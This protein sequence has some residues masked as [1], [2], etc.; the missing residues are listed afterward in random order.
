MTLWR[1]GH[2]L[3]LCS[4]DVHKLHLGSALGRAPDASLGSALI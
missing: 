1:S 3:A 4:S 2:L